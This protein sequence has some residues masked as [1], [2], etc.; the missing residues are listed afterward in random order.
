L[1]PVAHHRNPAAT[2]R[3]R[4]GI[5]MRIVLT[6]AGALLTAC[7]AAG[8]GPV[9]PAVPGTI[10]MNSQVAGQITSRDARLQDSSFYQVWQFE[11]LAGQIVQ[12]DVRS[13]DF[14]A[15]AILQD[16][17]GARIAY[18]DDSG[19]G[20]NA[21]IIFTLPYTG[22][23]RLL[24]NSYR[25]GQVGRYTVRLTSLGMTTAAAATAP[26]PGTKGQ[27]MRGQTI[28]SQLSLSDPKL[29]DGSTYQAWTFVGTAGERIEVD[30]ASTDFDAYAIIQDSNGTRL[31]SDDDSGGGTNARIVFTLPYSG[32]YRLVANAYRVGA[33]GTY[34]LAVR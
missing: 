4:R 23:Y 10:T 21:R 32:A 33:T 24:A 22:P 6:A 28:T 12:I 20:S 13:T 16:Q 26:L 14:D 17:S 8:P 15:Y 1:R 19:G 27:I 30:V 29:S 3:R 25:R 31:A 5:V 34:T 11:G 7:A 9:T 2:R 18:D